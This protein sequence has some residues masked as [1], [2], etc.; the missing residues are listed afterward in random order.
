M[1]TME[2]QMSL[3]CLEKARE[4]TNPINCCKCGNTCSSFNDLETHIS[5]EHLNFSPYE[6]V[7]CPNEL[8]I[9]LATEHNLRTHVNLFHPEKDCKVCFFHLIERHF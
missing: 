3:F 5:V 1:A 9:R 6:C 8:P 4:T 7:F 2:R